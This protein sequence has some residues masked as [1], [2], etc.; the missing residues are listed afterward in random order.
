MSDDEALA[1]VGAARPRMLE[2]ARTGDQDAHRRVYRRAGMPCPRCAAP[3]RAR[4]QGDDNRRTYWC[5]GCQR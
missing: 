5:P 2:S 4:G 3:I 1:L